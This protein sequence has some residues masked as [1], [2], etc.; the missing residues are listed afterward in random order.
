MK[1]KDII[2]QLAAILP[3]KTALFN[4]S[5]VASSITRTGSTVTVITSSAHNLSTNDNVTITDST[6]LNPVTITQVGNIATGTT[7]NAHDL[8]EV[9]HKTVKISEVLF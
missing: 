1:A 9:W 2:N 8:T 7:T 6:V 3:K 4:D 5:V